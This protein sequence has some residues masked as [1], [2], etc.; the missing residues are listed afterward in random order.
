MGT[1]VPVRP[2]CPQDEKTGTVLAHFRMARCRVLCL[3]QPT[4]ERCGL[5]AYETAKKAAL[6]AIDE[7][8]GTY[9]SQSVSPRRVSARSGTFDTGV[10]GA[11]EQPEGNPSARAAYKENF[12]TFCDRKTLFE[13]NGQYPACV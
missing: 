11:P 2:L 13:E 3:K 9:L 12:E 4:I 6:A 5:K 8:E 1:T 10:T 7:Y